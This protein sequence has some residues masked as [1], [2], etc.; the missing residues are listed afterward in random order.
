MSP[1]LV[2]GVV[3]QEVDCSAHFWWRWDHARDFVLVPRNGRAFPVMEPPASKQQA[4]HRAPAV[5]VSCEFRARLWGSMGARLLLLLGLIVFVFL[6]QSKVAQI[7]SQANEEDLQD[8]VQSARC[9]RA[10]GRLLPEPG[11]L[12]VSQRPQRWPRHLRLPL[13]RLY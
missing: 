6:M 1:S 11:R 8:P 4:F 5:L 3:L 9:S 7:S 2:A 13:E 10:A 12:V